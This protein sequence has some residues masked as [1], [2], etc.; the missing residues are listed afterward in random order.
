MPL[1]T[2]IRY[3]QEG[4][5]CKTSLGG[6]I[7]FLN[8]TCIGDEEFAVILDQK[9]KAC[10]VSPSLRVTAVSD[11]ETPG[12]FEHI[13]KNGGKKRSGGRFTKILV[14]RTALEEGGNIEDAITAIQEAFP[15]T[16]R[17]SAQGRAY[18]ARRS[19]KKPALDYRSANPFINSELPRFV[20]L[21]ASWP[22]QAEWP[23]GHLSLQGTVQSLQLASHS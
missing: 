14:A 20:D 10:I 1:R 16:T 7:E 22:P 23:G 19:L 8:V 17:K 15:G 5:Y 4:T 21:L 2:E 18:Q 12:S 9:G 13:P 6:T 3:L 11:R